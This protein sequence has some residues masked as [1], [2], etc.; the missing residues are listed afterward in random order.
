MRGCIYGKKISL[1]NAFFMKIAW[2]D[3]LAETGILEIL[4]I[5]PVRKKGINMQSRLFHHRKEHKILSG[6]KAIP[7]HR[8]RFEIHVW[9]TDSERTIRWVDR[10]D[11]IT[12]PSNKR[13]SNPT[14]VLES[15]FETLQNPIVRQSLG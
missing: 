13:V 4:G 1:A 15:A 7:G 12:P 3:L 8:N 9:S 10:N 2:T 11:T 14:T 6:S 5:C